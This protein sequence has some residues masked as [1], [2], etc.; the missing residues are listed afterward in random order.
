MKSTKVFQT[1]TV[2]NVDAQ[3]AQRDF[4]VRTALMTVGY[5][6]SNLVLLTSPMGNELFSSFAAA[7]LRHHRPVCLMVCHCY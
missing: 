3:R 2:Q 7:V 6:L 1:V 4:F 5:F